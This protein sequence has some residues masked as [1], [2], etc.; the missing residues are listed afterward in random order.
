MKEKNTFLTLQVLQEIEDGSSPTQRALSK[1]LGI[2]LGLTN[3]LLKRLARKGYIQI[4]SINRRHIQYVLTPKGIAEKS[5]LT[6]QF[7]QHSIN[8]YRTAREKVQ[9]GFRALESDGVKTI[10]FYG[11]GD[12]A[13]VAYLSLHGFSIELTG[14][15][16]DA[17]EG[18]SFFGFPI[19]SRS[20]LDRL[21]FERVVVTS[22]GAAQDMYQKLRGQGLDESAIFLFEETPFWK[23]Q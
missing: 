1:R 3:A 10:V 2:A 19:Y 5:R 12:V 13:E 6:Y 22:F 20:D 18:E 16:D 7:L 21:E 11:A 15:V 4:A 17:K 8:F 23:R 14:V 9:E